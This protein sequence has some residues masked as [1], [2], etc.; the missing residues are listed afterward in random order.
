MDKPWTHFCKMSIVHFMAFPQTIRGE[1]PI[2]ETVTQLA[3]DDFFGAV[4]I[5]WIKDPAVR[6]QVRAIL[7]AS[8][9]SVAF[10]AQSALLL[11]KLDLNSRDPEMRGRAIA[12]IKS[13][14]GEA[15]EL[16]ARRLALLSGPDLGDEHRDEAL[17]LLLDSIHQV[18]EYGKQR[19]VGITLETFDRKIEKKA[20]IGPSDLAARFAAQVRQDYPDFGLMYDLSHQPLLEESARWALTQIKD[21]LKHVH[22]GNAV[23]RDPNH[24]AYGDAHPRFGIAGG[25]NDVPQLV[26]FIRAL[27]AIRYLKEIRDGEELLLV[28]IEVKPQPGESSALVIASAKRVWKE[29][30]ARA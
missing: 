27:F 7:D 4:E 23:M 28:G 2:V 5:G 20:L 29:A 14:T 13:C 25:E 6:N 21:H 9:L 3:E 19:G 15:V 30:W 18:C 1:G 11:Q 8:H 17:R 24:P 10:G 16:G 12:Q 22:V 26:E